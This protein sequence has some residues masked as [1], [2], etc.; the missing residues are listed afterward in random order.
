MYV[1]YFIDLLLWR[2]YFYAVVAMVIQVDSVFFN[3][4]LKQAST[5]VES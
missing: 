5:K 3:S 4:Y 2:T 1:N